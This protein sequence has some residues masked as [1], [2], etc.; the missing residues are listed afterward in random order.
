MAKIL[1]A[2]D[3]EV[4]RNIIKK[5]LEIAG[6][7]V[8]EAGNGREALESFEESP[9]DVVIIDLVMPEKEGIETIIEFRQ[10]FPGIKIIAVSGSGENSP[11]LEM[12]RHLG[13]NAILDKPFYVEVLME[14]INSLVASKTEKINK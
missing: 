1:I 12:A 2:D 6:H 8:L 9:S 13:A 7:E 4:F 3:E 11:H 10:K 5:A 14:T